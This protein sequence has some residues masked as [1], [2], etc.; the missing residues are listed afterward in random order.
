M[1]Q[2][3]ARQSRDWMAA[4]R[5]AEQYFRDNGHLLIP[6][7]YVCQ[8]RRL[9]AWIGTQRQDYRT[10]TN[11]EFTQERID[12]LNAI[13]M[14]W[15][16]RAFQW[17]L[18][19]AELRRYRELYGSA[20]V[21]QSYVTPEGR[22]LGIWLNG[23]RMDY[24][25]GRLSE[26]RRAQL[27]ALGVV[28][29]PETLRR[30][31]W[32]RHFA[33]LQAYVSQTG[34]LPSAK[35]LTDDGFQLGEWLSN[36]RR[37]GRAGRLSAARRQKLEALGV[38]W[39][40][41]EDIWL[42]RYRQARDY[43]LQHGH[44]SA[45]Q[46]RSDALPAGLSQWLTAQRKA[47]QAGALAG[48][49][50]RRL[51]EI[52]MVWD[53]R[54]DLW[55][56]FYRQ[57]ADYYRQHGHLRVPKDRGEH[58]AL[59]RWINTQRMSR[60]EGKMDGERI[61][62]LDAIGMVWNVKRTPEELWEDWLQRAAAFYQAHG[63]LNPQ[64]G[65]LRTWVLAQRAKKKGK[66]G[67]LTEEQIRRLEEIG[68]IWEPVSDQ[69][70]AMYQHARDYY[71]V[72]QMLNVP[73]GY[74]TESGARLGNWIARQ[75]HCYRNYL[76]GK[77]GGG[78]GIITPERIALLNQLGMIWDGSQVTAKTSFQEKAILFYLKAHFP[79]AG[80]LSQWQQLGVELDLYLPGIR[81]AVEYDGFPWHADRLEQDERKGE[82]CRDNGI[83]L[84]RL[85]EPGLPQVRQC[86]Q[87]IWLEGPEGRGLAAGI[88]ALF[89]A[90]GLPYPQVDLRRD[91][92]AILETYR[93]DTARA[94]DRA[95][96]ALHRFWRERGTLSVPAGQTSPDG[97]HLAG[98][99]NAQREAY[100]NN[101]L[102][103]LQVKKLEALGM[104]W[105]PFEER[106]RRMYRLAAAWAEEHGNLQIP[107]G[108]VTAGKEQLGAWLASQRELY[109]KREL[110]PR[111]VQLLERLGILWNPSRTE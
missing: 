89:C 4:Y 84:I 45:Y 43:Y 46:H 62:K 70:Q 59:G 78:R 53:V 110:S 91:R 33:R 98:W 80:K 28:W 68:M 27:E 65:K 63:H 82:L 24:K 37:L 93:N 18:M 79:D 97:V 66:R 99:I 12:L 2:L 17:D 72:H 52:G 58:R 21:P 96:Q 75:R 40:V 10:R 3:S 39:D 13:G 6:G 44:L 92:P 103:G 102:T 90:L 20:R 25:R 67:C 16:V 105:A 47:R 35:D 23:V 106:W 51:E 29:T 42:H 100:R 76:E 83:R 57:A 60:R 36:Q 71:A 38:V 94:W 109:R 50:V 73:C 85:R 48:E 54:S 32:D 74:V 108:Y 15:D 49:K 1:E 107:A 61:R 87:V 77:R 11:R 81:T 8:G 7:D 88:A 111:R 19:C 86:D 64:E 14:V 5:L 104:Q 9:G 69:W 31:R 34:Q 22:R 101:E 95:Y 26:E 41:K 30:G 56:S 55:E